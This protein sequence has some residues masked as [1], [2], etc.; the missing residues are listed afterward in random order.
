MPST[1]SNP[2]DLFLVELCDILY[3]ER[4]LAFDVL[5]ALLKDVRDSELSAALAEHLGQTKEHSA[6]LEDVF[7]AAGAEPSPTLSAPFAGLK[8][9]HSAQ[10]ASV[11]SPTLADAWHAAAAAH[12]EHYEIA[13]YEALL[14]LAGALELGDAVDLLGTTLQ[15]ERHALG[16]AQE[17]YARL[18]AARS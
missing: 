6:R 9:Q 5:P 8:A 12:T 1:V 2:R 13:A 7:R 18:S 15:E 4:Q 3:V 10:A 14:P 16:A 17:A 11:V